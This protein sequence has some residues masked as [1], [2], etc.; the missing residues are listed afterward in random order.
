MNVSLITVNEITVNE[1][2]VNEIT[3]NE[4]TV[5]ECIRDVSVNPSL[6]LLASF[7]VL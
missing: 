2:T 1:I 7:Y 6:L 4:I 5:N 3:V